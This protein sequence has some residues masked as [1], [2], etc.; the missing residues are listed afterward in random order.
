MYVCMYVTSTD[1]HILTEVMDL[2]HNT[3]FLP[4]VILVN[5]MF[6]RFA[7]ELHY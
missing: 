7:F 4:L 2:R 3:F 1:T 5:M 6:K